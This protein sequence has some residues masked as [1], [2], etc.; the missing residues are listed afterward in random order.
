MSLTVVVTRDVET[1]Y[2]G[3]LASCA[4]LEVAPGVY[5]SPQLNSAT[6]ER[7]WETIAEW[8]AHLRHGSVVMVWQRKESP[9]SIELS[10]LGTP[11]KEIVQVDG[12]RLTKD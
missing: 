8:H 6:R 7:I 5:V 4:M 3:Y 2:R 12:L 10:T 9:G 11:L 1:R